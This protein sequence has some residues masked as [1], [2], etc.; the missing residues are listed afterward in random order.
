LFLFVRR[1]KRA[2]SLTKFG[3]SARIITNAVNDVESAP[4]KCDLSSLQDF[5]QGRVF[6]DFQNWPHH[7]A[8]SSYA[9]RLKILTIWASFVIVGNRL[10]TCYDTHRG[11]H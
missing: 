1:D 11:K 8:N 4:E 2:D 6:P 10:T 9:M 7:V 3:K 5:L